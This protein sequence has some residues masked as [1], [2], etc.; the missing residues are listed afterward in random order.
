MKT[1]NLK[2]ES[3]TTG[4]RTNFPETRPV[5]FR[6][7]NPSA[8]SMTV[9]GTFNQWNLQSFRLTKD[10]QGNWRGSLNLKPG[11]YEY[12]FLADGKWVDDPNAKEFA[13]NQFG[14]RNLVLKV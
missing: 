4:T 6:F 9:A 10:T 11:R 14:T 12:R 13:V 8:R 7:L 5:E 3:R 2:T 1:G